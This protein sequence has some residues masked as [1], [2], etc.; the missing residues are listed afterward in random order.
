VSSIGI[1]DE[2]VC[3]MVPVA[4]PEWQ[5]DIIVVVFEERFLREKG[6]AQIERLVP[7]RRRL[8][9]DPDGK[10]CDPVHVGDDTNHDN[11]ESQR[12]WK[13]DFDRVSDV[14]LQPTLRAETG[15]QRFLYFGIDLHRKRERVPPDEKTFDLV[16][17]GNNWYRWNDVLQLLDGLAKPRTRLGR[18]GIFGQYWN[19]DP[20][21]GYEQETFSDP[22]LLR[23]R[24]VEIYPP[25]PFDQVEAT[26]ASGRTSPV[27]VRPILNA[28]ELVTPRMF[29]TFAADTVPLIPPYMRHAP[30]LYGPYVEEL[31]LSSRPSDDLNKI[32]EKYDRYT[33]ISREICSDLERDHSYEIRLAQLV[34][35][36]S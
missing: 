11:A 7:R 3:Q 14:V 6:F 29:E 33:V 22:K 25:V 20:L 27:L 5:P 19:G 21:P 36:A 8:V 35:H 1:V 26:M 15:V 13:A 18:I 28:L 12:L 30:K 10:Y 2:V 32:L 23:A 16:Y 17:V 9:I 4:E 34:E 24:G 31:Q